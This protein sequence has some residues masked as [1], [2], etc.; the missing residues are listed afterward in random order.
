MFSHVMLGVSDLETSRK[1]YDALLGTLDVAP[2]VANNNRCFYRSPTGTFAISTPINGQS[3]NCGNGST[4]GFPGQTPE[5][6]DGFHAAG[7]A[8]GGA[9]CKEPP[10]LRGTPMGALVLA[11]LR[12]PG[13]NTLCGLHRPKKQPPSVHSGCKPASLMVLLHFS[14]SEAR[15]LV[16]AAADPPITSL[17][18]ACIRS[19]T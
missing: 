1:R 7:I 5:Q 16:I 9:T 17:P 4:I 14:T 19:R 2:D 6:V 13:G 15:N 10:G 12:D 11:Y 8:N 18:E 3:A